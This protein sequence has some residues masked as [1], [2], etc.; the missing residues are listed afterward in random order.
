MY[1]YIRGSK[2]IIYTQWHLQICEC[3]KLDNHVQI[4]L[5]VPIFLLEMMQEAQDN[6][7]DIISTVQTERQQ[8]EEVSGV[9]PSCT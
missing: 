4:V 8:E 9:R 1:M 3:T 2:T 7:G 6:V 5:H